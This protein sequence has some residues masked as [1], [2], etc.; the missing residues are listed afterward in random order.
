M[1]LNRD[2]AV[3]RDQS[4]QPGGE[5]EDVGDVRPHIVGHNQI[6]RAMLVAHLRRHILIE[7]RPEHRNPLVAGGGTAVETRLDPK[8]PDAAV[9]DMLEQ[10]SVVGGH[11][12][13]EAIRAKTQVLHRPIGEPFRVLHP[14]SG[15]GGVIGVVTAEGLLWRDQG[16]DLQQQAVRAQ[17]QVQRI[18]GLGHVE[19]LTGQK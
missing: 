2:P 10:V 19:L 13:D 5:A 9:D 6:G 18:R 7:E 3:V 15:V 16:W 11:L 14:R 8:T 17:P 1:H 4:T 12:D